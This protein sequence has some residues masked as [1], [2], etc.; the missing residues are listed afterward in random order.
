MLLFLLLRGLGTFAG[1]AANSLKLIIQ[2]PTTLVHLISPVSLSAPLRRKGTLLSIIFSSDL[3]WCSPGAHRGSAPLLLILPFIW[4][5]GTF[6]PMVHL[7]YQSV[8]CSYQ[9][10]LI[11]TCTYTGEPGSFL[12]VPQSSQQRAIPSEENTISLDFQWS[13]SGW[14]EVH[15]FC[16]LEAS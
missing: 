14:T 1:K 12:L 11:H 4:H 15:S 7:W 13:G 10:G 8:V 5:W 16:F 3:P 9:H 6:Q 2:S